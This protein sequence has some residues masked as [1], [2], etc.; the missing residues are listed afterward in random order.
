MKG[1]AR[2][3]AAVARRAYLVVLGALIVG[4]VAYASSTQTPTLYQAVA[5]LTVEP[6][7]FPTN[8][9]VD[10]GDLSYVVGLAQSYASAPLTPDVLAAAS[11]AVPVRSQAQ[12]QAEVHLAAV[13]AQ[14]LITVVAD[15]SDAQTA[16]D[17]A[18]NVAL[19]LI[20]HYTVQA[21]AAVQQNA[22]VVALQEQVSALTAQMAAT[23]A[24]IASAEGRHLS[25]S[26]LQL[27][28]M[29]EQLQLDQVNAQL[30]TVQQATL[31]G[32]VIFWVSSVARTATLARA[33]AIVSTSLGVCAGLLAGIFLALLLDSL[34]VTIRGVDDIKR[35]IGVGAL[36]IIPAAP[37]AGNTALPAMTPEQHA[38]VADPFRRLFTNLQLLNVTR[39][40]QTLL[41][42]LADE[43]AGD[44]WVATDLNGWIAVHLAV[45]AALSGQHTLLLDANW[46]F[47]TVET[48]FGLPIQETGLFT[49]ML[50][51]EPR[52]GQSQVAVQATDIPHLFVLAA[53]VIPPNHLDLLQSDLLDRLMHALRKEYQQIVI[54]GPRPLHS[55]AGSRFIEL[56]DGVLLVVRSGVASG[57]QISNTA[58]ALRKAHAHLT[59][60]VMLSDIPVRADATGRPAS[61]GAMPQAIPT[62]PIQRAQPA[63]PLAW[64][65]DDAYAHSPDDSGIA[66]VT[67][68]ASSNSSSV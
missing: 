26:A 11:A 62:P 16:Q 19:A 65:P 60:T 25:T 7:A 53:G 43:K 14:P 63:G 68:G 32:Q 17:L 46:D 13:P 39:T 61:L 47:P 44:D 36:G 67:D 38:L 57:I 40:Q 24:A 52:I 45:T 15:D 8:P 3:A 33:D 41:V 66:A 27:R 29:N 18:N 34:D 48:R 22:T 12:I 21:T 4:G 6:G 1:L 20:S 58:A 54:L 64:K 9:R 23:R 2:T 37:A 28:L 10:M 5:Q 30:T 55:G 56:A 51:I 35:W 49:S 59:G 31:Q 50:D 42:T